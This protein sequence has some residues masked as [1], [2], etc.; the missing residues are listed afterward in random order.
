MGIRKSSRAS[1]QTSYD[2]LKL[3]LTDG[4]KEWEKEHHKT[5]NVKK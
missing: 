3:S 2:M 4:E 1:Y 5:I